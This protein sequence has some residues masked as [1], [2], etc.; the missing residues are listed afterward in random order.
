MDIFHTI[1]IEGLTGERAIYKKRGEDDPELG[2]FQDKP[3]RMNFVFDLSASMFRFNT[4]DRRLERSMEVAL[5][6]MESF[7][8]FEHKFAYKIVGHSGDGANIEF[9]TPGK[10]PKTEK[11]AF[12]VINKMKAHSQYCLSGDNTLGAASHSMKEIVEEEAD[13]YFVVI[14]SDANIT[15]YNIHP[16]DIARSELNQY[17]ECLLYTNILLTSLEI[18]R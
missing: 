5:M 13:D 9:V 10:Y 11:E 1:S 7:R 14:M 16:N 17:C 8:G 15:Q 3:K 18:R 12:E 6:L 4:H 2:L